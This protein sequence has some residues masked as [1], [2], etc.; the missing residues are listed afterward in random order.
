MPL[1][2]TRSQVAR[3]AKRNS[4]AA[5][6]SVRVGNQGWKLVEM[7]T[8]VPAAALEYAAKQDFVNHVEM[9]H[10]DEGRQPGYRPVLI[11]T[12]LRD[13]LPAD[14][15]FDVEPITPSMWEKPDGFEHRAK[16]SPTGGPSGTRAKSD[17]ESPTKL[18]WK[19]AD[20]LCSDAAT[21]D[22]EL[23]NKI[24]DACVAAGVNKSTAQ[25]QI[26]RWAKSKS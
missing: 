1:Y 3:H 19:I 20:E 18:V 11:V 16:S 6:W 5:F 24:I 14:V 22:K 10:V 17:V 13:E 9:L 8:Q 23:R 7:A 26:Y 2:A 4:I 25:T 21:M 15:P 12:C